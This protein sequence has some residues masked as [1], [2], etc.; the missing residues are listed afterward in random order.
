MII[1][2]GLGLQ[3]NRRL[4]TVAS[5]IAQYGQPAVGFSWRDLLGTDPNIVLVRR[6]TGGGAGD[7]DELAFKVSEITNGTLLTWV[8]A[9]NDGLVRTMYSQGNSITLQQATASKQPKLVING[10]LQTENGLPIMRRNG[11]DGGMLMDYDVDDAVARTFFYVGKNPLQNFNL[12]GSGLG[13]G[14]SDFGYQAES[15]GTSTN[16]NAN[17]TP[18]DQ[19]LNLAAWSPSTRGNVYDNL[20]NQFL[21][22]VQCTFNY[23]E[24]SLGLGYRASSPSGR[25]MV[26]TQELIIYENNT[27][28]AG[29]EANASAYWMPPS[30]LLEQGGGFLLQEN[31]SKILL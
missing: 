16:I 21:I 26:D 17:L 7:D 25:G 11:A 2:L 5:Y 20:I 9:G 29:K 18:S 27:D 15:S 12:L 31:G 3:F 28:N 22:V 19:R 13:G 6:D 4:S 10:V 23:E 14:A 8:G 30:F 1:G 24:T